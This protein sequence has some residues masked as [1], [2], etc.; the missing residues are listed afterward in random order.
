MISG[1]EN[2]LAFVT[3]QEPNSLSTVGRGVG[4]VD[5]GATTSE[6]VVAF[7]GRVLLGQSSVLGASLR[8]VGSAARAIGAAAIDASTVVAVVAVAVVVTVLKAKTRAAQLRFISI[9][10]A[11]TLPT[12]HYA[13]RG[14]GVLL[15]SVP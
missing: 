5:P 9:N 1:T 7:G 8:G 12:G 2:P 6:V 15:C 3:P 13:T 14:E 10:G 11:T 4:E